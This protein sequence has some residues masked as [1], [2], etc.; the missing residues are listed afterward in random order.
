MI[1]GGIDCD[2]HP[3]LPGLRS[4]FPYLAEHW[5]DIFDQCG[6]HELVSNNYPPGAPLSLRPDWRPESG[7]PAQLAHIRSHVLDPWETRAGICNCLYGV[8]LLFDE[9]MAAA[10]AGAMNEWMARELL[11]REPRLRASIVVPMQ[12]P[13]L[14]VE[15]I[16]RWADD[17]RFVQVLV[18][19]MGD[20]PL[21]R[22]FYWPI[23]AATEKHGLPIGI[24][25]GSAYHRAG[26]E[27]ASAG[28]HGMDRLGPPAVRHRL[29]ALGL[30][31]SRALPAGTAECRANGSVVLRQRPELLPHGLNAGRRAVR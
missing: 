10:I 28:H 22:R 2:I 21:G 8:Q 24:H 15:E 13:E 7:P 1:P 20:M 5:R 17:V 27:R 16:E 9:H 12:N 3:T 31:R 6:M 25:A 18:L 11:D 26:G 19:V 14:A 23:Y 30:R 29:S 4:L